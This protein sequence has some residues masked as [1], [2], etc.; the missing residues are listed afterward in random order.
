MIDEIMNPSQSFAWFLFHHF[1]FENEDCPF[2]IL[3][4][5]VF[6]D[7]L[8]PKLHIFGSFPI[9]KS[10]ALLIFILQLLQHQFSD[11]KKCHFGWR[12][13]FLDENFGPPS[14]RQRNCRRTSFEEVK[15][16]TEASAHRVCHLQSCPWFWQMRPPGR[17][18]ESTQKMKFQFLQDWLLLYWHTWGLFLLIIGLPSMMY[19]KVILL[20]FRASAVFQT[21][22]SSQRPGGRGYQPLWDC[23]NMFTGSSPVAKWVESLII[24]LQTNIYS[25][26]NILQQ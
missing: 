18:S 19:L 22:C 3:K 16:R 5:P 8:A 10:Q 23:K 14:S 25:S 2:P 13:F 26:S 17:S 1:A 20:P 4:D 15:W 7:A 21:K 12:E 24:I 11:Q 9:L 6:G